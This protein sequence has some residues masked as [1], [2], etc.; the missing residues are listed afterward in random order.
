[1]KAS[2]GR[3]CGRDGG[4]L[5][6]RSESDGDAHLTLSCIRCGWVCGDSIAKHLLSRGRARRSSSFCVGVI[7]C[8]S[9]SPRVFVA[10]ACLTLNHGFLEGTIMSVQ[11]RRKSADL[12]ANFGAGTIL[13]CEAGILLCLIHM[14]DREWSWCFSFRDQ[15]GGT[16]TLLRPGRKR[17]FSSST[18]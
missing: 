16:R 10:A 13:A 9:P 15:A 3:C 17:K 12:A 2:F 6:R 14:V 11:G 5:R 1:M 18:P 4:G 7:L 8:T